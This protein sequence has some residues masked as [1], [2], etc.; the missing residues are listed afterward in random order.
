MSSSISKA[1]VYST[2]TGAS[3]PTFKAAKA[4]QDVIDRTARVEAVLQADE[5][6]P[7]DISG[8]N[9]VNE[10]ARVIARLGAEFLAALTLPSGRAPRAPKA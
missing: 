8:A 3:F 6:A 10:I 5:T 1:A 9:D 2:T 7:A 4:A